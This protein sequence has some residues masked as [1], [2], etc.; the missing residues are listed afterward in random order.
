VDRGEVVAHAN[1]A[2]AVDRLLAGQP[3][4]G[5]RR[6]LRAGQMVAEQIATPATPDAGPAVPRPNGRRHGPLRIYPNGISRDLVGRVMEDMGLHA[7]LVGDP[8]RADVILALRG[9]E[10]RLPG[11]AEVHTLKKNS[12]AELRRILRNVFSVVA[13]VDE[14][15]VR[16]AVTEAEHAIARVMAERVPVSLAPRPPELRKVQHRVVSR[17]HLEAASTGREPFR[18]LVIYPDGPDLQ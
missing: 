11:T 14:N 8:E 5:E 2:E 12:S 16:E 3:V 18:H 17:H 9:R 7:R 15:V 13:G 10:E 4:G 1:T 6:R